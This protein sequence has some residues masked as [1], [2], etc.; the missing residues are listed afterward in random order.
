MRDRYSLNLLTALL[1]A[2]LVVACSSRSDEGDLGVAQQ[3]VKKGTYG[4]GYNLH[5]EDTLRFTPLQPGSDPDRG[6]R[7]FGVECRLP[8]AWRDET[9]E[10]EE[11][12]NSQQ[13]RRQ[14][15]HLPADCNDRGAGN[16]PRKYSRHREQAG[17]QRVLRRRESLLCN[18]KQEDRES[19][20]P[21]ARSPELEGRR[22]VHR[23]RIW[24][25]Q[26][27]EQE[28]TDV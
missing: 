20:G 12:G 5:L 21:Q 16:R 27:G 3:P 6:R 18:T 13:H 4:P 24:R 1:S 7:L 25:A 22:G 9:R 23:W 11:A 2:A 8:H 17:E 15:K 19:T 14:I 26:T 28:V 10:H